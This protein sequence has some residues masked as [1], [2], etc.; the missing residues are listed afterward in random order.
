MVGASHPRIEAEKS[1]AENRFAW[2]GGNFPDKR[3]VEAR[4]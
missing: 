1:D 4:D 3:Q 2:A